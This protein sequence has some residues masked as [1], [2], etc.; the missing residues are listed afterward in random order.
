MDGVEWRGGRVEAKG[1]GGVEGEGRG[2]EWGGG[3]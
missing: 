2:V 3:R 1:R